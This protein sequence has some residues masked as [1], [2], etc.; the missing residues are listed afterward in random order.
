MKVINPTKDTLTV[1]IEGN[2]Y[3]VKGEDFLENV[4]DAH[5]KN[6]KERT[7]N[8][9]ILKEDSV[10]VEKKKTPIETI[11]DEEEEVKE[12][13]EITDGFSQVVEDKE[14]ETEL[15]YSDMQKEASKLGMEK[16]IGVSK[17]DLTEFI[18]DNS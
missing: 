18:K 6:W 11:K 15:S 7:H 1:Q 2:K 12:I 10:K 9:I 17:A 4:P 16:V 5:A 13:P 8:F 14:I 3:E